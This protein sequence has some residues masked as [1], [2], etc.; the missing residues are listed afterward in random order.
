MKWIIFS[1]CEGIYTASD[2]KF[3]I[4]LYFI[5]IHT[6]ETE[7]MYR[8]LAKILAETVK[9]RAEEQN[10]NRERTKEISNS[11]SKQNWAK[12]SD[13]E[14]EE[15]W[16]TRIKVTV[17]NGQTNRSVVSQP[18]KRNNRKNLVFDKRDFLFPE[19]SKEVREQIQ[20][21]DVA[22][23]SVT[24]MRTAD[25]ISDFIGQ[26]N[27]LNQSSLVITD[28]TAC[29]GGNTSSFCKKFPKVQAVEIDDTR[30]KMLEHNLKLLGYKNAIC[31]HENYLN[32]L[33][34]L[35]QDVVFIDPPW[36]GLSYKD[37]DEVELLL[38]DIP[39][40]EICESLERRAK[41]VIIKAPTNFNYNKFK[42]KISGTLQVMHR[43]RKMLL[44]VVD[45][46]HPSKV[47]SYEQTTN[48]LNKNNTK[49][50]TKDIQSGQ[51]GKRRVQ[52]MS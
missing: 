46:R 1:Q 17:S 21:D 11:T 26:L 42:A 16:K 45:Y 4:A 23:Y 13:Y 19:T 25:E 20:L 43:F 9:S 12:C 8:S 41:Y 22:M 32:L 18:R 49:P 28:A 29:A 39:L 15:S 3:L 14:D 7:A 24:D 34:T 37:Q 40:D 33:S 5:V 6:L 36:G 44:L 52:L 51:R 27:G 50:I 47:V 38:G 35:K 2:I 31:Y 30:Y 10:A 48:Q